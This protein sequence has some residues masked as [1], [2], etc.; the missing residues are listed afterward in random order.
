[1]SNIRRRDFL[2]TVGLGVLA[3][4]AAKSCFA[5]A[6]QDKLNVLFITVDDL[7]PELGC[8]GR[9]HIHSP[10]IDALAKRGLLFGRAYAQ[11]ALCGPSRNS[12]F[13]G[14]RPDTTKVY[15][16]P[17]TFRKHCPDI[18]ALPQLFKNHGYH[19]QGFGKILHH[20]GQDDPISWTDPWW[21]PGFQEGMYA[22]PDNRDCKITKDRAEN[23]DNPLTECADV[24]DNAYKDGMICEKAIATLRRVKDKPFFLAVGFFKPH[25]PFN[26]P[27]KYWDLY[28]RDEIKLTD[29][30]DRPA[31]APDIAMNDFRYV[32][33]FQGMPKSG[34][35]PDA[36]ARK[37][38]HAYY[39]C[40]S[41]VDAQVGRLLDELKR[42]GLADNTVVL[43]WGDHGYQLGDHG[44]WC[45]H[46]NFETSTHAPLIL[47]VPGQHH[48]GARTDALVEMVDIFPTLA[49]ACS[50]P[51]PKHL[52]GAS[53][54]PLTVN[55]KRPWK[56]AAFSQYRRGAMGRSIRTDRYRYNE[57][58]RTAGGKR[59][60]VARELYDHRTD[61]KESVNIAPRPAN[62]ALVQT[63]SAKLRAG[64]KAALPGKT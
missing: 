63:L 50:L 55:P 26:A 53:A 23:F 33:S 43:L 1:V 14:C 27:K 17:L 31:D 45:K 60:V 11:Q 3:R 46:T 2:K 39:A 29:N 59:T 15:G 30:P 42:L 36:L 12:V 40:V 6:S 7:R 37:L 13:S 18:V 8:Y 58:I 57:W 5:K 62:A 16:G 64:W 35:V 9:K 10:N 48:A 25:T 44:M 34:P 56:A 20:G 38:R 41:Y 4:G 54:L 19:T 51:L 49:D 22:H 61:P 32:R 21:A 28:R 52:E 47:H 24:P